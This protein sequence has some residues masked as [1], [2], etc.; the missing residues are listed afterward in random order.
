[1][2]SNDFR[3]GASWPRRAALR[4]KSNRAPVFQRNTYHRESSLILPGYLRHPLHTRAGSP[5]RLASRS[6]DTM[7]AVGF[8]P[9]FA[10][11]P[12]RRAS[13]SDA[14]IVAVSIV[15]TRRRFVGGGMI[16]GLKPTANFMTLLRDCRL[17]LR[18]SNA[19]F[20][21]R[22]AT[23]QRFAARK[24]LGRVCR[25][26]QP[27]VGCRGRSG[28]RFPSAHLGNRRTARRQGRC[29]DQ[30]P[31][32]DRPQRAGRVGWRGSAGA[33][34]VPRRCGKHHARPRPS[35]N[36]FPGRSNQNPAAKGTSMRL[37]W[38]SQHSRAKHPVDDPRARF[39][40][41]DIRAGGGA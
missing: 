5:C 4:E 26:P 20:V 13:R 35:A 30:R 29:R 39:L 34:V 21:E 10:V 2:K 37:E 25:L 12:F 38:R 24:L 27:L 22:K 16:R 8:N 7:V 41:H 32:A 15:A 11:V 23:I 14:M 3:T 6:D 1:L 40:R 18:E 33:R 19:A 31:D 9:R 28:D 17:S 36:E